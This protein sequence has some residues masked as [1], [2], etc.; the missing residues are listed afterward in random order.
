MPDNLWPILGIGA[1]IIAAVFA[2]FVPR[3][4]EVNALHGLRFVIVRWFHTGVWVVL[5]ISFFMRTVAN[6]ALQHLANPVAA[7]GGI[8]Y[9]VYMIT[10]MGSMKR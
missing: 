4:N 10:L 5:A 3:K 2:V 7:L 6:N 9:V 1:L 8:M